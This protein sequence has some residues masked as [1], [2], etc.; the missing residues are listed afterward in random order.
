MTS[1]KFHRAPNLAQIMSLYI[2]EQLMRKKTAYTK[3]TCRSMSP[4][5]IYGILR[6]AF[7]IQHDDLTLYREMRIHTS[8][9]Q[10]NTNNKIQL[11]V[12]VKF[13]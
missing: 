2:D 12:I 13:S 10:S 9:Y 1:C 6:T 5:I 11:R 4:F 8:N 3:R 7:R